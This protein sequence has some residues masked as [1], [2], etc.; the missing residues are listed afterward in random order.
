MTS[1]QRA[2]DMEFSSLISYLS[3]SG[4]LSKSDYLWVGKGVEGSFLF[5]CFVK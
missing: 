5:V 3:S 1:G 2:P 4:N